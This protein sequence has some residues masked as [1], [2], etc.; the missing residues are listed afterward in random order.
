MM[1]VK[2]AEVWTAKNL[3]LVTSGF[4][5]LCHK[6]LHNLQN[7]QSPRQKFNFLYHNAFKALIFANIDAKSTKLQSLLISLKNYVFLLFAVLILY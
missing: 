1:H 7:A 2:R 4:V 3:K 6:L 5:L